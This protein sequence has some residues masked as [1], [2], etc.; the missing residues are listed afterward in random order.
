MD[1]KMSDMLIMKYMDGEL[2]EAEAK[3]LNE[4]ILDC[5]ACRKEFYFYDNLV[6]GF[7]TL[8][9]IEAPQNFEMEVMARIKALD[10]S[11]AQTGYKTENK[12]LGVVFAIFAVIIGGGIG[13]YAF[14]EPIL[15]SAFGSALGGESYDKL[16]G[17]SDFVGEFMTM[18]RD[19]V[20]GVLS[21]SGPAASIFM[22]V[23]A[24]LIVA[25]VAL[26][27]YILYRKR[28]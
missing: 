17:V 6:K 5:E 11:Y 20:L 2:D 15:N 8:P 13:L 26:Q 4:H 19:T 1:C 10:H 14:R 18:I 21:S 16:I 7:E 22:G 27:G 25:V 28:R 24:V 23:I 3:L 12:I 9:E